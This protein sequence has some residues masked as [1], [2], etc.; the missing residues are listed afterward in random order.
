MNGLTPNYLNDLLPPL[1]HETTTYNLRNSNHIQSVRANTN[2]YFNSFIPSTIRAWNSL[3]DDIK[4]AL[5]VASF[6]YRLNRDLKKPPR[7]Y[8]IGTRIGQILHARLRMECSALNSHLYRK[9]I[10]PSPS[11]ICGGFESPYHFLFV[12]P[13]YN[14]ARNRYLPNNLMNYSTNDLLFGKENEPIPVNET[15]F[16]QVQDF[17]VK[18]GRFVGSP[19]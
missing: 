2:L 12:C 10:V 5:S 13:R 16:L 4:S 7:Y 6:K 15:L 18:S 11:C 19:L 3:S 17:I 14:A 8:N 9:N 1:V